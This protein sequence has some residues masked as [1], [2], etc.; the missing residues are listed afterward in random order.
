M[1]RQVLEWVAQHVGQA[2]GSPGRFAS[3]QEWRT[4]VNKRRNAAQ[5]ATPFLQD[6]LKELSSQHVSPLLGSSRYKPFIGAGLMHLIHRDA[7]K[8]V[9]IKGHHDSCYLKL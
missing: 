1:C 4:A 7:G 6:L 2:G 9:T 3:N 5:P 8:F